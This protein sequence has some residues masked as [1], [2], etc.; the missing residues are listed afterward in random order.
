VA[1]VQ[2]VL[3]KIRTNAAKFTNMITARFRESRYLARDN[4]VL[5]KDKNQGCEQSE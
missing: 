4:R 1:M 2:A 5:I 3:V